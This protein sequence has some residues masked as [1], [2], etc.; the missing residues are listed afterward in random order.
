[1]RCLCQ[2]RSGSFP[3]AIADTERAIELDAIFFVDSEFPATN[4]EEIGPRKLKRAEAA[5]KKARLRGC[6]NGTKS[7]SIVNRDETLYDTVDRTV[8]AKRSC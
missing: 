3:Q 6:S 8:F 1:M 7:S 5:R 2:R 4:A